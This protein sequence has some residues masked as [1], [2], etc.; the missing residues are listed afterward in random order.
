MKMKWFD[1]I[2]LVLVMLC[3]LAVSVALIGIAVLS[4]RPDTARKMR[5]MM[6][7]VTE[8][9]GT[10]VRAQVLGYHVAGKSG[11]ARKL[12]DGRYAANKHIG[13]F[14]GFAPATKPR[15]IVAVMIDEPTTGGYYGGSV[16]G[17]AFSNIM[18]GSLRILGVEPDA[19]SNN[20]LIPEQQISEVREET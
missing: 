10:A 18:A 6:V 2:L 7:A 9:G 3:M 11:T 17:P 14:V 19:P 1:R 4:E 13:L 5:Q 12:V 15:L 20:T 8:E 16:A